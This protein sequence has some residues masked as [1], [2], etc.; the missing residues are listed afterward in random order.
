MIVSFKT[1][2]NTKSKRKDLESFKVTRGVLMYFEEFSD[3]LD[4]S[5]NNK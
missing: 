1:R 2:F 5:I 3:L 4:I